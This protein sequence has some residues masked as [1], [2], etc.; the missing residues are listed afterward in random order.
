MDIDYDF[1]RVDE[2]FS[3]PQ[4]GKILISEPFLNDS[5][6]KRSIVFLTE[7][8]DEGAV[9]F[10]LNKP[11]NLTINEVVKD[12]PA[13][14]TQISIGGPVQT[15]TLHYIH[16]MGDIIPESI[17]VVGDIYWGGDFNTIKELAT[18]DLLKTKQIK[19][20]LGYSGWA[21]QQLEEEIERDSWVITD[22]E[23]ERVMA[24]KNDHFWKEMLNRLGEKYRLWSTF[25]ENP[26]MN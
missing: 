16:T 1:F 17:H 24:E 5:Y 18:L 22:I 23:P 3:K 15:N 11:V 7:H 13:I 9:G 25:P 12:F 20:F 26:T 21:A 4:K 8:S 10:V 19:F 2:A 14:D 6:F